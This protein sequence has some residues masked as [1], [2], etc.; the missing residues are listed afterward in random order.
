[1]DM[2]FIH[3]QKEESK[4]WQSLWSES[5]YKDFSTGVIKI[6]WISNSFLAFI[7]DVHFKL[8]FKCILWR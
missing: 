3:F 8:M 5:V 7:N 6:L 4:E 2:T 1:M